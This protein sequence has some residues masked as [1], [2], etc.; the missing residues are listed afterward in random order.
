MAQQVIELAKNKYGLDLKY[1]QGDWLLTQ[2]K[3]RHKFKDSC[4]FLCNLW[5]KK[6]S[7]L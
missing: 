1:S 5:G 4:D 7:N 6:L 3:L 2:F